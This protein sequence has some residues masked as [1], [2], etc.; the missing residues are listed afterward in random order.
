MSDKPTLTITFNDDG[1]VDT[2]LDQDTGPNTLLLGLTTT[3]AGFIE[4]ISPNPHDHNRAIT[5][6]TEK[7]NR[8]KKD[9]SNG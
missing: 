8:G 6:I 4:E 5:L 2:H 3:L 7:L 9:V 1:T